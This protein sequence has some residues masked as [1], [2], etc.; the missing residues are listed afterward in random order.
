MLPRLLNP[1]QSCMSQPA[2]HPAESI[3]RSKAGRFSSLWACV[4]AALVSIL[5]LFPILDLTHAALHVPFAYSNGDTVG[6]GDSFFYYMLTKSVIDHGWYLSNPSL[7]APGG[8]HLADFPICSTVHVIAV[9]FLG[10]LTHDFA[11]AVNV[12]Y[13]LGFPLSALAATY[14]FGRLGLSAEA[15]VL[16]GVLFSFLPYHFF[17]G[18]AHL[19]LSTYYAVPL[20]AL[21]VMGLALG[22]PVFGRQAGW[23]RSTAAVAA[24][25]LIAATD[26]YYAFF[27]AFFLLVAATYSAASSG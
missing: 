1:P 25:V 20:A 26:I 19:F 12:Y 3:S 14:A 8:M 11:V 21:L 9:K 18:Q 17:R 13:L 15:S 23:K 24:C 5:A 4:A 10:W 22:T 27:A 7:G 16:A 6:S 2:V